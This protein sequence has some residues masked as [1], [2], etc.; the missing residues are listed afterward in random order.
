MSEFSRQGFIGS[1]ATAAGLMG[2][3]AATAG[4]PS[5]QNIVPDELLAGPELS[6]SLT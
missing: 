6:T 3:G 4:D 1:A 2:A 5:F